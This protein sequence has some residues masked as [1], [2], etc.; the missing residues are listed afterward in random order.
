MHWIA[1]CV[2]F[3]LT[4]GYLFIGA[5]VFRTLESDNQKDSKAVS[6]EN[7]QRF[8]ENNTCVSPADLETLIRR[9]VEAYEQGALTTNS[10]E[11]VDTWNLWSSFFFSATVVTTIGY[12]HISPSTLG[13]RVFFIFYA[14]FGIP[15]VG[16][17]LT[18][19]GQ[20]LFTP[21][22]KLRNRPSNKWIKALISV[23]VGIVGMGLLIFLPA[24]GFHNFEEWSY[25]EAVYYAVVT[26]TTVGFGDFVPGQEDKS[27]RAGYQILTIVWIFV[28]LSWLAILLTDLG[29]IFK[30]KIEQQ[31]DRT[32]RR[33][34]RYSTS[35]KE[36]DAIR[37]KKDTNSKA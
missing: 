22:K 19:I 26:L 2:L 20:N 21:I 12:G 3:G 9:V 11:A 7:V 4:V 32:P 29:D 30:E 16:I 15:L 25:T 36:F 17:F 18:G 23:T 24:L 27:Y 13:G 14:I 34:S 33:R 37:N 1:L 10:T 28:G 35:S 31:S 5:A 8:L 6:R